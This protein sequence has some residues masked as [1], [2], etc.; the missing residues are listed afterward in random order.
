MSRKHK[1]RQLKPEPTNPP[2]ETPDQK[3]LEAALIKYREL[4]AYSTDV[5]LKEHERFT[6]ADE[7]ASKYSGMFVFLLGAVTF[8]DKWIFDKFPWRDFPV[9]IPEEWPL[10]LAGVLALLLSAAGWFV[11]I[12]AIKLKPYISR[13][14]NQAVLSFFEKEPLLNIYYGLARENSKAYEANRART[15]AKITLL[16]HAHNLVKVTL[17]FLAEL[18]VM[19]CLYSWC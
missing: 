7:K 8:F 15:D 9:T 5:L 11:T 4:Y 16:V 10:Y 2:L 1:P 6:R 12:H 13:P 3:Q 19:Y 17:A 18:L 14:L